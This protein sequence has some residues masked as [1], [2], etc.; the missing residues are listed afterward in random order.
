M[1]IPNISKVGFASPTFTGLRDLERPDAERSLTTSNNGVP[2]EKMRWAGTLKENRLEAVHHD[3]GVAVV[4]D[5]DAVGTNNRN[6]QSTNNRR[7][8]K[9]TLV[10][11][12]TTT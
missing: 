5:G 2:T 7:N 3:V 4:A 9:V 12:R 10:G 6:E 1:S 8:W 11:H